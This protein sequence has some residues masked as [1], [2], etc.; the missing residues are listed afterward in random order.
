MSVEKEAKFIVPDPRAY[1]RI[2]KIR[3]L[4]AFALTA[5]TFSEILDTY[6]DTPGRDVLKAGYALRRREQGGKLLITLKSTAPATGL[7]HSRE[8]WEVVLSSDAAPAA[9]PDGEARRRTLSLLGNAEA[10]EL[11]QLRQRRFVRD[12]RDGVRRVALVSLDQVS[13][14]VAGQRRD[15]WELEIELAPEGREE[16]LLRMAEW[17]RGRHG[18]FPSARSKFERAMERITPQM[19]EGGDAPS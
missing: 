18:L 3:T 9:W 11:F 13:E 6:L 19:V 17:I 5:G 16:E 14:N 10:V 7:I 8:E 15:Y 1:T 12:A 2:R 4:A